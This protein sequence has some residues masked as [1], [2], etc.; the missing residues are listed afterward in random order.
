[1]RF[2]P[3]LLMAGLM[4]LGCNKDTTKEWERYEG[5]TI[6]DIVGTY[7][8]S[9]V[10][11]AFDGLMESAYCH[12]CEDAEVVV[13]PYLAS[14]TSIEFKVTCPQA[15]FNKSF[16]G[17]PTIEDD[18]FLITMALPATSPSPDYELTTYVYK[19]AKGDIRLHG[20]AR[21]IYYEIVIENGVYVQRV[22]SMTNYYFDVKKK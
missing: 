2:L 4:L 19:N 18:G 13:S 9:Y 16:T 1:M 3:L 8:N 14:E 15:A 7:S 10:S 11:D 22:K 17:R 5:Y 21:H 6:D 20:F 12:I